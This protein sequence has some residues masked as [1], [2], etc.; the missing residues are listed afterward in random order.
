MTK[1]DRRETKSMEVKRNRFIYSVLVIVVILLGLGSRAA[2]DLLPRWVHLYLGD[3]LWSLMI[4]LIMGLL[5]NKR[6]TYWIAT[7]A[8]SYSFLTEISQLYQAPWINML[9]R[10]TIGG[11]LLGF[12]FLWSDLLAYIM[13]VAIGVLFEKV[14]LLKPKDK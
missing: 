10:T 11:L 4:F 9:R 2:S 6:S 7:V 8:I 5:F 13:G 12:G 1:N 14:V 3:V